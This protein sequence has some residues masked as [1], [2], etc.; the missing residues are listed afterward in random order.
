[1]NTPKKILHCTLITAAIWLI[2]RVLPG[3]APGVD[4]LFKLFLLAIMLPVGWWIACVISNGKFASC[5]RIN[6]L[7]FGIIEGCGFLNI[8]FYLYRNLSGYTGQ[9]TMDP[10]G[11]SYSDYPATFGIPI[12]YGIVYLVAC[13]L[14][15]K[16]TPRA[17]PDGD[18]KTSHAGNPEK[19]IL[20]KRKKTNWKS[21]Q[22]CI[23]A[24]AAYWAVLFLGPAV[25]LLLNNAGYYVSGAGWGTDSLMYKIL[26]FLSQPLSCFFAFAAAESVA[27][28]RFRGWLW[29]NCLLGGA[30]CVLFIFTAETD[31]LRYAMALSALTC[32][33]SALFDAFGKK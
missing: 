22:I 9:F 7:L 18:G 14:L 28:G 19:Q 33:A 1:M 12:L 23:S 15:G 16:Y 17:A 6:L 11:I 2:A 8:L 20:P 32:I 27:K 31:I 25:I 3:F 10:Y 29:F 24:T 30:M 4:A 13:C 5:I 21:V 26:Q